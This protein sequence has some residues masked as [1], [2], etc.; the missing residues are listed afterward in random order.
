MEKKEKELEML[1]L[2]FGSGLLIGSLLGILLTPYS[3]RELRMKL[4]DIT[5]NITDRV[6]RFKEPEKYTRIKP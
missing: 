1:M 5:D 2:G 3:G 4:T 6:N